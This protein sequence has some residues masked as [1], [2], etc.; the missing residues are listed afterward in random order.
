MSDSESVDPKK[1][2]T[3]NWENQTAIH[4]MGESETFLFSAIQS[5]ANNI[6]VSFNMMNN[7]MNQLKTNLEEKISAN[8][9]TALKTHIETEVGKVKQELKE[10]INSMNRKIENVQKSYDN[11]V[12]EKKDEDSP[13][14]I[15]NNVIIK[16]LEYDEREKNDSNVTLHKVQELF[17]DGLTIP[18]IK[19]RKVSR[20]NGNER[21]NGV[22]VVQLDEIGQKKEIFKQKCHLK[23]KPAYRKVYIDNDLPVE[24]RMFQGNVRTLLKEIG[25]ENEMM[26]VGNKLVHKRH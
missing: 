24:T 5:L 23:N 11:L 6:S 10:D 7:R 17:R 19:I 22:V 15:R 3:V 25:K 13:A 2:K 1:V 20:K 9:Q 8:I 16:N 18:N 21:Y 14:D 12:S 4:K 26:F